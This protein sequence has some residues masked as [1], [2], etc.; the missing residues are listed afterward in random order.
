MHQAVQSPPAPSRQPAA[1]HRAGGGNN[2]RN[3]WDR[4]W[5]DEEGNLAIWQTPNAWLI[6]WAVL[7]TV[8]LFFNG[9]MAD[10]LS[11]IASA[12]LI[13]WCVLEIWKGVNYFRRVLGLA[14]LI[15]AVA[16][17]IKVL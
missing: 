12:S 2:Q 8:S 5:K 7:T 17:L 3:L 13:I 14:V 10:V 9:R 4:C 11:W 16:A 15:Y 1:R 6:G